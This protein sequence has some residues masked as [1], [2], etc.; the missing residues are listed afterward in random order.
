MTITEITDE[1]I[2]EQGKTIYRER[3]RPLLTEA[4]KGKYVTINIQTGEYEIDTDDLTGSLRAV[5]RFGQNV[6]LY[7]I[8][9]GYRAV[10]SFR[11]GA[12][13]EMAEW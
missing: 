9:I 4:D 5:A 10:A 2:A 12:D 13:R 6:P 3:I 7:T 11:A 1:E 8:R